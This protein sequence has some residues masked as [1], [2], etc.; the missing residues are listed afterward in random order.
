MGFI[1]KGNLKGRLCSDCELPVSGVAVRLYKTSDR[2][3]ETALA[4]ADPKHTFHQLTA[5][6]QKLKEKLLIAEG[7]LQDNGDFEVVI[8]E[9]SGYTGG[10]LDV[11]WYCGNTPIKVGPGPKKDLSLQFHITTLQPAWK[12]SQEQ[13]SYAYFAYIIDNKWFCRILTLLDIWVVS[14][15]VTDC[16]TKQPIPGVRVF[17][18]DVDLIQDDTLGDAYTDLNGKFT[19]VYPGAN[20]R[21]TLLS[22]FLNVEWPA[23]PDYYFRIESSSGAVLLKEDRVRGRQND[24]HNAHNCFCVNLCVKDGPGISDVPWF[25]S[26]GYFNITSQITA[27]GKTL[28]A[29]SSAGGVDFG[30]FG[31]V[32][33]GGYATKKVPTASASALWYRFLYSLDNVN[34]NPVTEAQ[35]EGTQLKVAT[36]QIIWNGTTAFQNV[37]ID[38]NQPASVADSVPADNFPNPIPDHVLRL[39][40]NGWVRVDQPSL[41]NGFIGSLL[42]LNT[43]TIIGGGDASVGLTP[44]TPL[45]GPQQKNGQLLYIKFQTTDDPTNPASPNLNTQILIGKIYVNNWNEVNLLKL[46]ELFSGGGSG[47]TPVTAHA[48]V[49]YTADHELIR[50]WYLA[51]SSNAIPGGIT[52]LPSGSVPRGDAASIDLATLATLSPAFNTWPSCAYSVTLNTV[53]KLTTGEYN[54]TYKTNQVIF[55]R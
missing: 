1:I 12:Q 3:S 18:Y 46:E 41:D 43:N 37:V 54:D 13:M 45:T 27:S 51:A 34:Y 26:V 49:D 25:T 50:N 31:S 7:R 29:V 53:R 22:P 20:F 42:W 8:D 19:I 55:C 21:Q 14:G 30:F 48:H 23:G 16:V 24:R 2:N 47:C 33:L 35:M 15:Y 5:D 36:R 9:K 6:E 17:A 32:K 40:A 28:A 11:D 38:K 4:T 44:G 52:G 39:D 10:A